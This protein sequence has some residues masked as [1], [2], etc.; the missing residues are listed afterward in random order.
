MIAQL[1]NGCGRLQNPHTL[2]AIFSKTAICSQNRCGTSS[3]FACGRSGCRERL[4]PPDPRHL[5]ESVLSNSFASMH[6]SWLNVTRWLPEPK[7][8]KV[9]RC[10]N[11]KH[12]PQ[13]RASTAIQPT[14][15]KYRTEKTID[16]IRLCV[17][18]TPYRHGQVVRLA[19]IVVNIASFTS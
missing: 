17:P 11:M 7:I 9:G 15:P 2:E 3:S 1:A 12:F 8:L 4:A 14:C 5:P 6:L 13:P 18:G 16:R 19:P 10:N